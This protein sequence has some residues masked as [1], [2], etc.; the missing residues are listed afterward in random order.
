MC[1][2][3]SESGEENYCTNAVTLL[4]RPNGV[5]IFDE[6]GEKYIYSLGLGYLENVSFQGTGPS[7]TGM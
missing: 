7:C 2:F 4:A 3:L 5:I 1:T 6:I